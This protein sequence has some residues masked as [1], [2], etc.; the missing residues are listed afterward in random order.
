LVQF[1]TSGSQ[2]LDLSRGLLIQL[3]ISVELLLSNFLLLKHSILV[4]LLEGVKLLSYSLEFP[5]FL[6]VNFL[7]LLLLLMLVLQ[8][9]SVLILLII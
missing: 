1:D 6:I 7:K 4:A 5:S 8:D 2:L 9:F 3:G